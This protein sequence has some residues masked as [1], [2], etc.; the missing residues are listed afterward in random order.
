MADGENQQQ[1]QWTA[2]AKPGPYTTAL[3]PEEER[4]FQSWVKA[5]K[6]PWRDSPTSDYDMRGYWKAQQ[7]GNAHA[8]T[9]INPVD[10]K[11]H[12]PDTWKTP[13]HKT[14][15]SES[16]YALPTAGHWEGQ[17]FVPPNN[18]GMASM[19]KSDQFGDPVAVKQDAFGPPQELTSAKKPSLLQR[20]E[21]WYTTPTQ[22]EIPGN[23]PGVE[24]APE[25]VT[26]SPQQT[27]RRGAAIES[28]IGVP[29]LATGL[30]TATAPT[31]LGLGGGVGGGVLGAKGGEYLGEKVGA[32]ELGTD[33][34]GLAGSLFG[35]YA[36]GRAP[37]AIKDSLIDATGRP[38]PLA[39]L[40][41]GSD[42][43][44]ALGELVNPE[45]AESRSALQA[46]FDALRA[47]QTAPGPWRPGMKL[48]PPEAPLGSPENPGWHAKLPA[49][50][51]KAEPLPQGRPS[52]FGDA[53]SSANPP[54]GAELPKA[55]GTPSLKPNVKIV[56]AFKTE[57]TP[58][59]SRI[60]QPG[61]EAAKPPAVQG[62]YWSFDKGSLKNAVLLGDR[63]AAIVYKQR[64]GE[65]P[66]GAKYLT[67]I[68]E[69]PTRGLYRG[70]E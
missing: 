16:Q 12:Y 47:G 53:T 62:S 43:A 34:G 15:S 22:T 18:R 25:G 10:H 4:G 11:P 68:A 20:A 17:R 66:P 58:P 39:R 70:K 42:R 24:Q 46:R 31:L 59:P 29:A 65:L 30:V 26:N 57:E 13:Y 32:P 37:G 5:N 63:D 19:A 14:F 54:A 40:T 64:F 55:G 9:E 35:G 36:G 48:A 60:I 2:Y 1:P 49:R 28:G 23:V 67:D 52:L 69:G 45:L 27:F 3:S 38:K 6:I 56:S 44:R 41:L 50:M 8:Q 7:A 61:T 21:K 51:P 33:V